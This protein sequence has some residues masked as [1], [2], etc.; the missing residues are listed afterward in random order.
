MRTCFD[1]PDA[2]RV[3]AR[4]T[5]AAYNRT[6]LPEDRREVME[7][8]EGGRQTHTQR[9]DRFIEPANKTKPKPTA[10]SYIEHVATGFG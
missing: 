5:V 2:S 9:L 8:R 3:A 10:E 6:N 4:R 1:I 7:R